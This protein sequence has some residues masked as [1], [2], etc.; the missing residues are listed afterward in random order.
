VRKASKGSE[1]V[2]IFCLLW[3]LEAVSDFYRT[4]R[5]TSWPSLRKAFAL[6]RSAGDRRLIEYVSAWSAQFSFMDEDYGEMRDWL[7]RSMLHEALL[8]EA[9]C[10]SCMI[11]AV[12]WQTLGENLLAARWFGRSREIARVL[13]D[14]ATI[15]AT[16]ANRASIAL[17][18]VWIAKWFNLSCSLSVNDI[19]SE[20]L[21]ALAYEAATFSEALLPQSSVMR[22]RLKILKGDYQGALDH[23]IALQSVPSPSYSIARASSFLIPWLRIMLG[24]NCEQLSIEHT[25]LPQ[26][27]ELEVDDAAVTLV[28]LSEINR[29]SNRIEVADEL[30]KLA[31]KQFDLLSESKRSLAAILSEESRFI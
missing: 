24:Q 10:R 12:S 8:P 5:T 28:V 16:I 9:A 3:I 2:E 29:F 27:H 14:R 23:L 22:S 31:L 13:G 6:A 11:L 21:G 18:D 7:R 25:A 26:I 1:D 19:E 20:L 4:G 17:N 15:M 30:Q